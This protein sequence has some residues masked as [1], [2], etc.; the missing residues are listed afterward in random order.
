MQ[1]FG[2]GRGN[3]VSL[4]ERDCSVQRR[5]QKVIEETPAP[6][7]SASTRQALADTAVRLARSLNYLS[8][9]TV[10]Y[11]LDA[12][13]GAFYFL[14]VNTRLQVE[15]GVTELVF[16][17]D[18][19][20]WMIRAA[21][22][23]FD[24]PAQASLQAHGHAMQLRVYA[25]DPAKNFQ[26]SSGVLTAVT[27]ADGLRVDTWVE[28]GV[29]VSPFYDPLLAKLLVKRD[30]RAASIAA[31]ADG[32]ALSR[33]DGIETNLA[34]LASILAYPTFQEGRQI[35]QM[36]AGMPYRART[37]DI[38]EGGIQSTVQDH[39]G[40]LGLWAVG[41]PPSGPM[42]AY[43]HRYANHLLGNDTAAATVEMTLQ[44]ASMRF[45]CATTIALAGA[46]MQAVVSGIDG[47]RS[48][49]NWQAHTI[50]AGETL[51]CASIAGAGLRAYLAFAGGI[52]VPA[53]LGSRATF[54]LGNFG[55]HG[56]R[57]LRSGDVLKLHTATPP[58]VASA[59]A[60]GAVPS[61]SH[62]WD[63]A[64]HY[65]PHGAP[66]FFTD[67]DI[68][69]FFGTDWQVHF[70]SSRTGVRLIGPKPRWARTDGGE[71]GLHPSNIHDNAYAIGSIDFTGD[72]PVILGP[73]GPSLG[74]FVCPAV[75]VSAD[76]WKI[77]QLK[78]GD[79][80][81]F[82]R[83]TEERAAAM[84]VRLEAVFAAGPADAAGDPST[85]EPSDIEASDAGPSTP[86]ATPHGDAAPAVIGEGA[87]RNETRVV[88]RRAGDDY[89]LVEFGDLVLDINLRF[90][91]H[92]LMQA[93]EQAQLK[94]VIDLTPGIRS[95]QLHF[96]HRQLPATRLVA[97]IDELMS[98]LPS[99][100]DIV[101]PS[102]I[103]HL[104][105]A[106]NDA[107]TRLAIQKYQTTVR[108]D[109]PWCPSNIEF[110]QRINGLASVQEVYDVVFNA[111]YMVLGL[112]DVYLGAPVATPIDPRHRLVT[113]KY[114]PARTWT[115]EN[116]VGIGG[117]YLCVYGMEGPGG[118]QFVG[119]TVQMWNRYR[120]TDSFRDS[121]PWLLRFFDQI[122]FYEVSEEQLLEHRRDFPLGRFDIRIEETTFSLADYNRFL[123]EQ[124]DAIAAFKERQQNAFDAER[125]RWI[126]SGQA[127]FA[128]DEA[129][130]GAG[131]EAELPAGSA[132]LSAVVPGS[133]WKILAA[134]GAQVAEGDTI[135]I[136]ESMKM[137][138][139]LLATAPGEL[140]E[141]LVSEGMPVNGGQRIAII[142]QS[143]FNEA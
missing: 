74:G 135:A 121:K 50:A 44:G 52:D 78:P 114:N 103:V 105:L 27:F 7:L 142:K 10:E 128:A 45:N 24:L 71:A 127:D 28:R 6:G 84:R 5:N 2:D 53:Y 32:L 119:R 115:P 109:A 73:D 23:G 141:W 81:R 1:I 68:T 38:L 66:D 83:V 92:A 113:T 98:K 90:R 51:R 123:A 77:G 110:I 20:E 42:D 126:A 76:L 30:D 140:V 16:G 67:E 49:A 133:V 25:E 143:A 95:L 124:G 17:V 134:P 15:H 108:P 112:G 40:R 137:E 61:Y 79:T 139:P 122:R 64:V 101:V 36:L 19:V 94:G 39:P 57:A 86:R 14:E 72:M 31:L 47:K 65:G 60:G 3:V 91:V 104:P 69:M 129:A 97:L 118:Y 9:G 85:A 58:A 100:D 107:Q 43:A 136:F 130:A 41:V 18:L 12:D 80:V 21:A 35:T 96:D 55:G 87:Y 46:D 82:I 106:W 33:I 89:L 117:A 26:P 131:E 99:V 75:I 37:V 11:V 48:L 59:T 34:Y 132:F 62:A 56:G 8:A 70:N 63:I 29:T 4:G 54:T 13:S 93:I 22:P 111:S 120:Q 102:R 116:A 138:I 125:E 88:Y